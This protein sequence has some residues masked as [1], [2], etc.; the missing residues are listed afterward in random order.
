MK[1]GTCKQF[2]GCLQNEECNA[3]VNYWQ[4][5]GEP[6]LGRAKRIPCVKKFNS[7][8]ACD[9][10]EEPTQEEIDESEA[11]IQKRIEQIKLVNPLVSEIKAEHGL[12]D[13][14]GTK[15]CPVCDG[16]LHYTVSSVNGH[17]WGC[18]ETEDCLRW[19]E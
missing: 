3:G 4:L 7:S 16:T 5:V 6:K 2:N 9:K 8:I 15:Q 12:T 11:W 10:Y 17:V 13:A 1:Q 14:K 19:M 18:C